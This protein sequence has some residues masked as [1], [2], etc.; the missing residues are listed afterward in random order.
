MATDLGTDGFYRDPQRIVTAVS[1]CSTLNSFSLNAVH[2]VSDQVVMA[3]VQDHP[4]IT[5]LE[6]SC[7]TITDESIYTISKYCRSLEELDISG[8][9][10]ISEEGIRFLAQEC[11]HIRYINI[12][13]CYNVIPEDGEFDALPTT[14]DD[15]WQTDDDISDPG[16]F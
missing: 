9:E 4:K 1:R 14:T 7:A 11:K 5:V 2:H 3:F 16:D 10:Q 15:I 6:I 13:D 12:K 8:C